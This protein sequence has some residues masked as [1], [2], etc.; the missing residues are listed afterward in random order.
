MEKK[1]ITQKKSKGWIVHYADGTTI[2]EEK[3]RA[4]NGSG[5]DKLPRPMEIVSVQIHNRITGKYHTLSKPSLDMKFICHKIGMA[6]MNLNTKE[7]TN[8][9]FVG[10]QIILILNK[11]G[12]CICLTV[13]QWTGHAKVHLDNVFRIIPNWA[14][15]KIE[16]NIDKE[17][18]IEEIVKYGD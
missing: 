9:K 16:V 11:N 17:N 1:E 10:E 12:N 13:D 4:N 3:F 7:Q 15:W 2:S 18:N 14:M 6:H 8:Q 5:F